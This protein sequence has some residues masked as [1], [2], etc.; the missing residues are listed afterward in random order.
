M[1]THLSRGRRRGPVTAL[2]VAMVLAI[3]L[4]ASTLGST[5][6]PNPDFEYVTLS[7]AAAGGTVIALINSGDVFDGVTFEGIPDGLGVVPVGKGD[8]YVDLYVAFE[9]SHVPFQGFADFEDSSVQR[10]RLDLKTMQLTKLDEVLPP[11]A[12]FI[13]FCSAFMAG[14]DEGFANHTF[15]VNEESNDV[16]DVPAGAPY[17]AD[18]STAPYRQAGYSVALDTKTG[19]FGQIAIA[20]RHNH[21]NTVIVPGGWSET[22][23]VSGDDTFLPPASQVYMNTATSPSAFTADQGDLWA[24]RVTGTDAG[25]VSAADPQNNANDYLEIGIGDTWTGEFIHV[26]D[27]IARGTTADQPQTGLEKWSN[28]NNVFQFVRVED[29]ATDPD[30]PRVV[31]F[32]DTGST[33]LKEDPASGRL[34]RAAVDAVPYFNT[35]GRV[36]KMVLNEDDPT[37]VDELSIVAQGLLAEQL[38][39]PPPPATP[40]FNV[41]DPGV[42]FRA[43]DNLDVGHGSLMLQEDASNAKIWRFDLG[44]T[45]THVGTVTHPTVPAAGESSGIIDMSDWLGPGWWALD[46]QSHVNKTTGPAGQT[47]VTPLTG[48]VL[49]YQTRREDGQLLLMQVPGS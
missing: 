21:E 17:G 3:A 48:A 26:P 9:Q 11:S 1:H 34:I 44:S 23:A 46:V 24:F 16:I 2:T 37:I 14:P 30:N 18:P 5:R 20:G 49:T 28:A 13:R 36:F 7:P 47:Y 12:G 8:R 43:P 6:F 39:A 27:A 33:R 29:M 45:W 38:T 25:P 41:I 35:D 15:F 22:V 31:Y 42:G 10:A 40:T 32:T 4:P 19:S